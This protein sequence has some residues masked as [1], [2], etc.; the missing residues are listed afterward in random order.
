MITDEEKKVGH[1]MDLLPMI[2]KCFNGIHNESVKKIQIKVKRN[3]KPILGYDMTY[4]PFTKEQDKE[5]YLDSKT[6]DWIKLEKAK[7]S[8]SANSSGDSAQTSSSSSTSN[9]ST[10][11]KKL[12]F[13]DQLKALLCT[14]TLMSTS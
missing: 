6:E 14:T 11:S 5:I 4:C 7:A 1:N 2:K 12:D 13:N 8:S 10:S 9:V 3:V